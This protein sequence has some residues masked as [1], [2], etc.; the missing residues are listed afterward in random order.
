LKDK[1][2]KK[3]YRDQKVKKIL[4]TKIKFNNLSKTKNIYLNLNHH[5]T[6]KYYMNVGYCVY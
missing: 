1:K 5:I 3:N 2:I 4:V 6:T